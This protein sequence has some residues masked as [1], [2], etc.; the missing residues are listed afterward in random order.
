MQPTRVSAWVCVGAWGCMCGCM[1]VH[2][3]AHTHT[4]TH[5]T[6]STTTTVTASTASTTTTIVHHRSSGEG[7]SPADTERVVTPCWGKSFTTLTRM[8]KPTSRAVSLPFSRGTL[9]VKTLPI[10]GVKGTHPV[11]SNHRGS[12]NVSNVIGW[13]NVSSHTITSR[14]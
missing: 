9:W 14:D 4:C 6:T 1:G 3:W 11:I 5:T 13:K 10:I 8:D 2:G 12:L 7:H